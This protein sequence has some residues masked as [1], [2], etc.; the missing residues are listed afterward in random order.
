M[1][2]SMNGSNLL[3]KRMVKEC[4][5]STY[6]GREV[7]YNVFNNGDNGKWWGGREGAWS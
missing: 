5:A 1:S 6:A 3:I 7:I 4:G 2:L